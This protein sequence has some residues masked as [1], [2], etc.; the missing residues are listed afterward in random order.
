MPTCPKCGEHAHAAL[1]EHDNHFQ[2]AAMYRCEGPDGRYYLHMIEW[3]DDAPDCMLT[4]DE[5]K[6]KRVG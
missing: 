3:P 4:D 2:L 6:Q 5:L 1:R